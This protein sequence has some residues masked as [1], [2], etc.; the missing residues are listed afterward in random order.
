MN[1]IEK[2]EQEAFNDNVNVYDYYLGEE[3]LKGFYINGNIALNTS[4]N[5]TNEKACVLAE[6]LGHHYTTVGDITSQK[7]TENQKQELRARAWAYNKLIG[8][9]GI[10]NAYK[11]GCHNIHDI[12]EHLEVSEKFLLESL[13]YYRKKYGIC[14]NVDNYVVYFEPHLGIMELI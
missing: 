6:E 12:A 10:V 11:S 13:E 9:L 4:I 5:D 2:L 8:L 1:K 14:A 7:T 3:N